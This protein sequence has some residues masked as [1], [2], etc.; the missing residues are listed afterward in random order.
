MGDPGEHGWAKGT[1]I[2]TQGLQKRGCPKVGEGEREP[3][4][5]QAPLALLVWG[6]RGIEFIFL[7]W[8][9]A[10]C[11]SKVFFPSFHF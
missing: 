8:S 9:R 6:C 7:K 2:Q 5:P 4:V 3:F 10:S 11:S 1:R